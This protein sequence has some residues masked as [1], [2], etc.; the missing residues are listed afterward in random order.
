MNILILVN[1]NSNYCNNRTSPPGDP[2]CHV[3]RIRM[4]STGCSLG[5]RDQRILCLLWRII[6]QTVNSLWLFFS[7][8]WSLFINILLQRYTFLQLLGFLMKTLGPR[9][10]PKREWSPGSGYKIDFKPWTLLLFYL[11]CTLLKQSTCNFLPIFFSCL[12]FS[13]CLSLP[14][15]L[16]QAT[17]I[18][19]TSQYYGLPRNMNYNIK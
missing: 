10:W 19:Q 11:K 7:Q 9:S 18:S 17:P 14:E 12:L 4:R 13:F 16:E 2:L 1:M 15:S 8:M 3:R 6:Q 5:I